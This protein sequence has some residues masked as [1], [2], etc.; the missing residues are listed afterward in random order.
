MKYLSIVAG[1]LFLFSSCT[2]QGKNLDNNLQEAKVVSLIKLVDEP[3]SITSDIITVKGM[4]THVCKHGGQ[5]MFITNEGQD[6]NVL[7]R[8]SQSI[9]EFDIALEGSIVEVTGKLI[10]S[11]SVK[12]EKQDHEGDSEQCAVEKK[13]KSESGSASGAG[14]TEISYYIEAASFV[15]ITK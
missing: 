15:E 5:K 7:V 6:K 14:N 1:V 11:I 9:P 8:V 4:V 12:E 2:Q 13:V 3:E 10:S